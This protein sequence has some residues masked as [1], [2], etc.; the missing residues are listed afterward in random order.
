MKISTVRYHPLLF[1]ARLSPLAL[2][3]MIAFPVGIAEAQDDKPRDYARR[4][5]VEFESD[6]LR[7]DSG[8]K[9][10]LSRFSFGSSASPAIYRVS[11]FINGAEAAN[12]E[13]EFKA[14]DVPDTAPD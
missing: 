8:S 2:M 5:V 3:L 9:V 10:D 13:V 7:L 12:E 4:N 6:L 11:I 1:K 14:D